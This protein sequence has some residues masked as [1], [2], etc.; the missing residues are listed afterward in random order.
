[1]AKMADHVQAFPSKRTTRPQRG[2][3]RRI[4]IRGPQ[5]VASKH[6]ARK[7]RSEDPKLR[8]GFGET[9]PLQ[10][11]PLQHKTYTWP[12]TKAVPNLHNHRYKPRES[13]VMDA[14]GDGSRPPAC[15]QCTRRPPPSNA[16]SAPA[17][18]ASGSW[19]S[20]A[21]LRTGRP[22]RCPGLRGGSPGP[23]LPCSSR[24]ARHTRRPRSGAA[25]PAAEGV[26]TRGGGWGR[27]RQGE[28]MAGKGGAN[29]CRLGRGGGKGGQE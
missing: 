23:A 6:A 8:W 20:A 9:K 4:K 13:S 26:G 24:T 17:P 14:P 3:H 7:T 10:P 15:L 22:P 25:P 1:M 27:G 28:I 29:L 11:P 19:A 21:R 18:K 12:S 16:P 2:C 5:D